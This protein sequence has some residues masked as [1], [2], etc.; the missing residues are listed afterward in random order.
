MSGV[1]S[2]RARADRAVAGG[3]RIDPGSRAKIRDRLSRLASALEEPCFGGSARGVHRGRRG[4]QRSAG[5]DRGGR[6]SRAD[7]P[8]PHRPR[9]ALQRVWRRLG[10]GGRQF[11]GV[12]RGAI[13]REL[14]G[15]RPPDR[16][17]AARPAVECPEQYS[18][19]SRLYE[20]ITRI[21]SAVAPY[22]EAREA[23][24][25]V[26]RDLDAASTSAPALTDRRDEGAAIDG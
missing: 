4:D 26:L 23:V 5:R 19:Q 8:L 14:P 10:G 21:V 16:R 22:P 6:I 13:A 3:G 15:L 17:A 11:A 18:G 9:S 12:S 1:Q 2:P 20:S 25:A 7:R 24:V